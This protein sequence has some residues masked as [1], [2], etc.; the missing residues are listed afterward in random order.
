MKPG[1][2]KFVEID[3]KEIRFVESYLYGPT[4]KDLV[5]EGEKATAAGLVS[6]FDNYWKLYDS[7]SMSLKIGCSA[8]IIPRLS[9]II[10]K[11]FE[12]EW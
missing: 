5:K 8:S 7:Y 4:H 6:V 11:E 3:G 12:D 1:L 10:G 9:Q 2:Y